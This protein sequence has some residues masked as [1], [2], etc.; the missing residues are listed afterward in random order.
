MQLATF[1]GPCQLVS[2]RWRRLPANT[3]TPKG[4]E[5]GHGCMKGGI[6]AVFVNMTKYEC[7]MCIDLIRFIS[8]CVCMLPQGGWGCSKSCFS[9]WGSCNHNKLHQSQKQKPLYKGLPKHLPSGT[10]KK[11]HDLEFQKMPI[12]GDGFKVSWTQLCPNTC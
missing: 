7:V 12:K 4:I 5:Y 3:F 9:Y 11:G 10:S 6:S 1:S 8:I 2:S